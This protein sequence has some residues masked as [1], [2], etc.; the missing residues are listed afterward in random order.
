MGTTDTIVDGIAKTYTGFTENISYEDRVASANVSADGSTVLKLYYDR[1]TYTVTFKDYDDTVIKTQK[2][3]YQDSATAPVNPTRTGYLFSKWDNSFSV[4]SS[5][6]TVIALYNKLNNPTIEIVKDNKNMVFESEGLEEAV[7]FSDEERIKEI[8]IKLEISMLNKDTVPLL[9]KFALDQY[10]LNMLKI[11]K[12]EM[13]LLDIKL[14]KVVEGI[15]TGITNTDSEITI[16]FILPE[17][18]RNREFYIGRVHEGKVEILEYSYN[19]E[20]FEVSFKTD[21]FSTYGVI[22]KPLSTTILPKTGNQGLF[23]GSLLVLGFTI[24][25]ASEMILRKKSK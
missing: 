12:P 24:L 11:N 21:K 20:T 14:F 7:N 16:R 10:I 5:D 25:G 17:E 13:F 1:N 9:D 3:K 4:V 23:A 15:E 19:K 18:Y 2:V 8:S 6:I 22:L